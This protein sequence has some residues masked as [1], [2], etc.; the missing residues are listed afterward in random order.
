V[1]TKETYARGYPSQNPPH[2]TDIT[3]TH[4]NN[5]EELLINIYL[6][7]KLYTPL[8]L[9]QLHHILSTSNK[10]IILNT[11]STST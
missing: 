11:T 8:L 1:K 6:K 5:L 7:L 3:L 10:N 9:L 2:N 4:Q